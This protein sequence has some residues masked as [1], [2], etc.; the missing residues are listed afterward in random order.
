MYPGGLTRWTT[1]PRSR[2]CCAHESPSTSSRRRPGRR[3]FP[4]FTLTWA[5][6]RRIGA[7]MRFRFHYACK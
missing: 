5:L 3:P 2:S 7:V 4:G 6:Q 1:A